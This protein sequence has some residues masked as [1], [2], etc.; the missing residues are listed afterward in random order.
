LHPL[1]NVAAG[2]WWRRLFDTIRL[3][4]RESMTAPLPICY[5]NGH[6]L[7]WRRRE[8]RRSIARSY[9][10]T[11]VYEVLPIYARVRFAC[12]NIWTGS[13]AV[14]WASACRHPV[15]TPTGPHLCQELISRNSAREA[16]L[17]LQVTRGAELGA[18]TVWPESLKPT[19]FAYVTALEPLIAL[20][21][22]QGVSRDR[23][24][25]E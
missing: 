3:W 5:L 23:S 19:W 10:A 4:F 14:W 22:E 12:A 9:L 15:R 6:Y 24:G 21:L 2:G 20:P 18:I 7:P 1:K 17:Y 25:H 13:I 11:A 16:Y 8:C